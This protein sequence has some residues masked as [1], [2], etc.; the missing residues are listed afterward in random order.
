MRQPDPR[1]LPGDTDTA[2]PTWRPLPCR[3]ARHHPVRRHDGMTAPNV[4]G[5]VGR[6]RH[7]VVSPNG[8]PRDAAKHE[9]HDGSRYRCQG[10]PWLAPQ[11]QRPPLRSRFAESVWGVAADVERRRSGRNC[12]PTDPG[13]TGGPKAGGISLRSGFPGG[14]GRPS[15]NREGRMG[16]GRRS[17]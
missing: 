14:S 10:D 1:R 6:N 11:G 7:R 5:D 8:W 9:G 4:C 17:R 12:Q 15:F 2:T 13:L 16:L 3:N